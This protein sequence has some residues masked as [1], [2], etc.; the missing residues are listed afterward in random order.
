[1]TCDFLKFYCVVVDFKDQKLVKWR[2]FRSL[3]HK[4]IKAIQY[5]IFFYLWFG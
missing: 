4:K 1:M 2:N 3:K 5:F